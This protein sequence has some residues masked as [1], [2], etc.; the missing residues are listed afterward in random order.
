M[1]GRMNVQYKKVLIV[2]AVNAE[3]EAVLAGI[4]TKR[5]IDVI[6]GGVG[7]AEAAVHTAFALAVKEYD[8]VINAGIGGG[9]EGQAT[10]GMVALA[11]RVV[12]GDLGAET[13][14]GFCNIDTLGF[15]SATIEIERDLLKRAEQALLQANLPFQ[16]GPIMTNSTVTGTATTAEIHAKRLPGVVA[17]AMEGFG[18]GTAAKIKEI[19]FLEIRTIS[20]MV[21]PRDKDAWRIGDALAMLTVAS[22]AITEVLI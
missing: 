17:E 13:A 10:I 8:Y 3:K 18:V 21:G 14:E 12:A 19:P 1:K 16:I 4:T 6:V 22:R 15:G 2:T 20:N 5:D 9:F 11:N 7:V